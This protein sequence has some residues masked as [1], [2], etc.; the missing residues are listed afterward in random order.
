VGQVM[1]VCAVLL[2]LRLL[3]KIGNVQLLMM[4]A[5]TFSVGGMGV[6]WTLERVIGF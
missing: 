6:F 4:R 2:T 1:F 5:A 3:S